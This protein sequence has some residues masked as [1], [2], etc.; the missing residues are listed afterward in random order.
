M[1]KIKHCHN[2]IVEQDAN[3]ISIDP[4]QKQNNLQL[5]FIT[6]AHKDH[7]GQTTPLNSRYLSTEPTLE[8]INNIFEAK[9]QGKII[10]YNKTYTQDD[11]QYK[12]KNSGH[13]LGSYS[14]VFEYNGTKITITSDINTK[15]STTTKATLPEDT[16][17]LIIESTYGSEKDVFPDRTKEYTRLI[18]WVLLNRLNGKLPI[19]ASYTLG[20]TQE[21]VKLISDNTNLNIGLTNDAHNI[22]DIYSKYGVDLKN[23]F[24]VNGNIND[25]DLLVLPPQ[26]ITKTY[27]DAISTT[28]KKNIVFA[29]TTGNCNNFGERFLISDHCDVNGLLN[30]IEQSNAKQVYTY[31]GKDTEFANIVNKKLGCYSK[32]LK[33]IKC[34]EVV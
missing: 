22:C 9:K 29:S 25:L 19:I 8:I 34:L 31:H 18:K 30:Y 17:I 10:E 2:I 4:I 20:K 3:S 32:A 28:S 15:D 7:F 13:V 26:K 6:H 14:L 27:I 5:N 16:D 21:I 11:F 1:L 33:D 12:I 23:Y 24:K